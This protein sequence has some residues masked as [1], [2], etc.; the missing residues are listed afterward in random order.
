VELLL[1][2]IFIEE[3]SILLGHRNIKITQQR[4]SLSVRD[5]QLQ[6]E[7]DLAPAWARDPIVQAQGAM[8]LRGQGK[9]LIN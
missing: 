8:W 3:V 5:R 4:Y 6:L 1:A 9:S 7:S 2:G